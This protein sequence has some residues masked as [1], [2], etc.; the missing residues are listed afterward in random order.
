MIDARFTTYLRRAFFIGALGLV[1]SLTC[2]GGIA[3]AADD[4]DED[5]RASSMEETILRGIGLTRKPDIEY[6]E[7]SPLVVPPSRDLPPPES[8]GKNVAW[9]GD[10]NPKR[11]NE[12]ATRRPAKPVDW[13]ESSTSKVAEPSDLGK[14]FG[15]GGVFKN[16]GGAE[17]TEM[18]TFTTE[19][20]RTS[21][22]EPPPGYKTPSAAAPY[23]LTMGK[24]FSKPEAL[25]ED[26]AKTQR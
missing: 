19:P 8:A 3:R 25:P 11:A 10:L 26:P 21:L 24:Q 22:T 13:K 2:A 16:L 6:R 12:A 23:G 20:P 9:P 7:R 1:T 14:I 4:E 15:G 18:G 17:E 5:N